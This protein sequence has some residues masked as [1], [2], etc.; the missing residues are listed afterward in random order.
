MS[1]ATLF[2]D[3]PKGL[4]TPRATPLQGGYFSNVQSFQTHSFLSFI[5]FFNNHKHA[6]PN[7]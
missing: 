6:L 2:S 4:K 7:L 1:L 5:Y 3:K